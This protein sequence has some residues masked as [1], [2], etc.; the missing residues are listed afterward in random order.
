LSK[1]PASWSWQVAI[2][3]A[4]AVE[5]IVIGLEEN[6]RVGLKWCFCAIYWKGQRFTFPNLWGTFFVLSFPDPIFVNRGKVKSK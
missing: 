2:H 1:S 4:A 5:L 3:N 6:R